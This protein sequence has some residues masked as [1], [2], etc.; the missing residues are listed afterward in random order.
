MD[1]FLEQRTGRYRIYATFYLAMGV[2]ALFLA[3]VGLYA[4]LSY[5]VAQ[6]TPEFGV[7][8]AL[9]APALRVVGAVVRQ[10]L[11]R[12]AA[13]MMVGFGLAFWLA[14]GVAQVSYQVNPT[15]PTVYAVT[16][17]VL[18]VAGVVACVTP[19]RNAARTD[20]MVAIRSD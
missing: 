17:G 11:R 20:P 12:I 2:A 5:S 19:A 9:G 1:R 15:D 14:R 18:L 4:V 13:G 16:G 3:V 6:R 10:G 7:R 8:I